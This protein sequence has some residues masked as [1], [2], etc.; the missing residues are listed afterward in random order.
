MQTE[1]LLSLKMI[2]LVYSQK[3]P[4]FVFWMVANVFVIKSVSNIYRI[5]VVDFADLLHKNSRAAEASESYSDG[6]QRVS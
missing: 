3:N 6:L 4:G 5:F 2:G 1:Q